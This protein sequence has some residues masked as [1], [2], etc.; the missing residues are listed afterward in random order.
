MAVKLVGKGQVKQRSFEQ[1][2][3]NCLREFQVV[4]ETMTDKASLVHVG[5]CYG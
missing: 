3:V 5:I 1:K 2:F 4:G